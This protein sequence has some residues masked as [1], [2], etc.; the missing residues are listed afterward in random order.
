VEVQLLLVEDCSLMRWWLASQLPHVVDPI[1]RGSPS[2]V[3]RLWCTR[4]ITRRQ[5]QPYCL[6]IP[7]KYR[8]DPRCK[9]RVRL[10][11]IF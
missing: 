7:H 2:H 1:T 3:A 5:T 11:G 4:D 10:A 9:K 8:A 6:T